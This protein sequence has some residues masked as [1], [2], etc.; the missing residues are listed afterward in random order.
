MRE[1]VLHRR[2][3]KYLLRMPKQRQIEMRDVLR[4]ITLQTEGRP[5]PG[6]PRLA[7]F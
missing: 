3:A 1:I 5:G 7:I 6:K 4:D 2:A